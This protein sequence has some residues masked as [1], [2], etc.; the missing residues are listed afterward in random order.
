MMVGNVID[1]LAHDGFGGKKLIVQC[2]E[3]YHCQ[4]IVKCQKS[5]NL[6]MSSFHR[7]Y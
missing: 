5:G 4:Y 3:D 6:L 1:T 7:I 2:G